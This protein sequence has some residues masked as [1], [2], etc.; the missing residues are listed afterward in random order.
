[1]DF[2]FDSIGE[3]VLGLSETALGESW[4]SSGPGESKCRIQTLFGNDVWWNS[5]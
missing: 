4:G 2:L 5:E 3:L 1:M